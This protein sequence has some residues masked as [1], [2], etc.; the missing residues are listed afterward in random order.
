MMNT[1]TEPTPIT[2]LSVVEISSVSGGVLPDGG[3]FRQ[4]CGCD[5]FPCQ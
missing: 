5:A 4:I 3:V 2:P 1:V